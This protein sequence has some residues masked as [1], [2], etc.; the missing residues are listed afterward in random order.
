MLIIDDFG[1][2]F[3]VGLIPHMPSSQAIELIKSS[4]WTSFGHLCQAQVDRISQDD[5]Q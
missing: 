3:G 4:S 1:E 2:G 5:G